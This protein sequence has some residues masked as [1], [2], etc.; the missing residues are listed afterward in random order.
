MTLRKALVCMGLLNMWPAIRYPM[1]S[2][3]RAVHVLMLRSLCS[4]RMCSGM[5]YSVKLHWSGYYKCS[6]WDVIYDIMHILISIAYIYVVRLIYSKL[7]HSI[8]S[9]LNRF[10]PTEIWKKIEI[11]TKIGPNIQLYNY[12]YITITNYN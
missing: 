11:I 10:Y 1:C 12:I 5:F 2:F 8:E 7:Q 4:V 9:T 6:A 3:V